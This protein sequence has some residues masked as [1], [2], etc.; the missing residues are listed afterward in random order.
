[1]ESRS[2]T[3]EA[4]SCHERVAVETSRSS[5]LPFLKAVICAWSGQVIVTGGDLCAERTVVA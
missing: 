5:S 4:D 3:L 2:Y 1:M